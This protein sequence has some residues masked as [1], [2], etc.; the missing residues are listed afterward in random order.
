MGR[1]LKRT[2]R[3]AVVADTTVARIRNAAKEVSALKAVTATRRLV[4]VVL[5]SQGAA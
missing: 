1:K 5:P 4:R 2:V 3:Q